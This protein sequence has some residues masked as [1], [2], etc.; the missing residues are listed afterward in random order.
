[1]LAGTY[2]HFFDQF[3]FRFY[4]YLLGSHVDV[5]TSY[6]D[7]LKD[8]DFR[9]LARARRIARL[10]VSFEVAY[11]LFVSLVSSC[12]NHLALSCDMRASQCA[13]LRHALTSIRVAKHAKWVCREALFSLV[14]PGHLLSPSL[15]LDY[16]RLVEYFLYVQ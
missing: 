9:I 12:S 3:V 5:G 10:S 8:Q 4:P 14:T 13:S 6:D 16:R 7:A 1:M 15:F 2:P 11:R